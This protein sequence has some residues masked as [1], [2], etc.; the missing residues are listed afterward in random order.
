MGPGHFFME[1]FYRMISGLEPTVSG[2]WL[3]NGRDITHL[4]V[5]ER[6]V[7]VVSSAA[8]GGSVWFRK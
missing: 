8:G 4:P 3:L 7:G 1:L 5:P 6:H 2:R